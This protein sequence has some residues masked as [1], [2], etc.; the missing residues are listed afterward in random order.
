MKK[1][2]NKHE[3]SLRSMASI[4]GNFVVAFLLLCIRAQ[5][6]SA[7]ATRDPVQGAIET[8][9]TSSFESS[10]N[11]NYSSIANA[12][13][14]FSQSPHFVQN[15]PTRELSLVSVHL[16]IALQIHRL[17][18]PHC[19]GQQHFPLSS[20]RMVAGQEHRNLSIFG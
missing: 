17:R 1:L 2:K 12:I 18:E 14:A 7:R 11:C 8:N 3:T 9:A 19:V 5:Q 6:H 13:N 10:T 4:Y 16:I 15:A 20:V